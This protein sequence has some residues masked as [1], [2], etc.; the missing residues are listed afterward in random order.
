MAIRF[1]DGSKGNGDKK[2]LW[3]DKQVTFK[4]LAIITLQLCKN[5]DIIYPKDRCMYCRTKNLPCSKHLRR[6]L[7]GGQVL[8]NF[9]QEVYD[10]Q[11]VSEELLRKYRL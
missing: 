1:L 9:L 6:L 11:D 4:E 5:E 10:E 8:I 7:D 2:I 3:N